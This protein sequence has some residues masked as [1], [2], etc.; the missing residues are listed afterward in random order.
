MLVERF[1]AHVSLEVRTGGH[2]HGTLATGVSATEE[3]AD[4]LR[5]LR[6]GLPDTV[7]QALNV[8]RVGGDGLGP[9]GHGAHARDETVSLSSIVARGRLLA[10]LLT[11]ELP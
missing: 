8:S 10:A 9:R 11:T 6:A 1:S 2:L 3:L 5:A 7:T 4:Q